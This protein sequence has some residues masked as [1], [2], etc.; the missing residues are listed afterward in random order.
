MIGDFTNKAAQVLLVASPGPTAAVNPD[1]A[2]NYRFDCFCTL[3]EGFEIKVQRLTTVKI[4]QS[5][6]PIAQPFDQYMKLRR[7]DHFPFGFQHRWRE[8]A[9]CQRFQVVKSNCS[10]SKTLP[11]E[12]FL[13]W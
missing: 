13:G 12:L 9:N 7:G 5:V 4:G 1:I 2:F 6:D 10:G 11:G 8:K 3:T